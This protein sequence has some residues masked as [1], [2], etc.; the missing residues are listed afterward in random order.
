MS[1]RVVIVVL[2]AS[3]CSVR[4]AAHKLAEE[5]KVLALLTLLGTEFGVYT[6]NVEDNVESHAGIL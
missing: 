2:G 4:M 6:D 3:D 1:R 5:T